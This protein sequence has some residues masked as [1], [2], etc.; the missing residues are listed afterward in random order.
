M[1]PDLSGIGNGGYRLPTGW[2]CVGWSDAIAAG[3]VHRLHY[4]GQDL[5][6]YR[7]ESGTPYALDPHCLHLGA[8]LGVGGSVEGER[9]VCPWHHWRWNGDGTHAFIP[10]SAKRCMPHLRIHSWPVRDWCGMLLVWHDRHRRPPSWEPPEV[11]EAESDAFYPLHPHSRMVHRVNTHPQLIVENAADPYHIGPIHG[12]SPTRTTSFRAEGHHLHAT[13]ST[14]YGQGKGSTWLTPDGE[15]E[16]TVVYDTYG[17]GVGFVRFPKNV[18][19]TVQITSHTPVDDEHTDYWFMQASVREPGDAGDAPSGRAAKFL[20]LQQ[21]VVQ[22]DF[23]IWEHLQYRE[24]P[25]FAPEEA[26]DYTALRRWAQ[27]FYPGEAA[28]G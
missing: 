3:C 16:A 19:E 7:G 27:A 12:G 24:H 5:V 14:V 28:D 18:L 1:S 15:R 20:A 23:S 13:I 9:I 4:F 11:P 17:L 6:C 8:H 10:Y 26:A 22:Q 21:N 2:F 25:N